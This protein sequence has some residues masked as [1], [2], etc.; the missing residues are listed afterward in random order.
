MTVVTPGRMRAETGDERMVWKL[1]ENV[2]S[3]A[4]LVALSESYKRV[5]GYDRD[6]LKLSARTPPLPLPP[7]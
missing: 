1:Q 7:E 3:E 4:E 5:A 2:I 6:S